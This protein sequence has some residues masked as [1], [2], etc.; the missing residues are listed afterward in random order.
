MN[1]EPELEASNE[2]D[3]L[4]T[5]FSKDMESL[6]LFVDPLELEEFIHIDNEDNEEY[7]TVVLE[8]VEELLEM[9][10]IA[11][12]AMDDDGDV[13]TQELN[14]GFKNEVI[15]QGFDSLYKQV[16]DIKDQLLCPEVQKEA[17]E[18]FGDL[19]KS[20]ESFQ[21]KI[22]TVDLKAKRKKLQNLRQMMINDKFN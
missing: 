17:K 1:L 15:F 3:D 14:V 16:F 5:E 6:N 10:K 21:S 20:F 19:K 18:T 2:V 13:N 4:C 9:M 11:K 22:R 12:T 8:D 7:A